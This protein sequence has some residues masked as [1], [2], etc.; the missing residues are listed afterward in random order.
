MHKLNEI[1]KFGIKIANESDQLSDKLVE[2]NV[3]LHQRKFIS[4]EISN[5]NLCFDS[6][7][8]LISSL[9]K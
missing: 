1:K 9:L 5:Y 3:V 4:D 7:I 8:H 2:N 6:A